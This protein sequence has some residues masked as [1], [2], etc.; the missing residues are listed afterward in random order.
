MVKGA[1]GVVSVNT[2]L[3]CGVEEDASSTPIVAASELLRV[4][5]NVLSAEAETTSFNRDGVVL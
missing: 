5:S 3:G 1:V 4:S 2:E